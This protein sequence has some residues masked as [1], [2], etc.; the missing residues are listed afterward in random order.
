MLLGYPPSD[1][2]VRDLLTKGKSAKDAY[3][4]SLYFLLALLERTTRVITEDLKDAHDRSSRITKFR[5]FMTEGQGQIRQGQ[6]RV[7][8]GEKRRKYYQEVVNEVEDVSCI[9]GFNF[10]FLHFAENSNERDI[11]HF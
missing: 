3:I 5:E 2:S 1:D 11:V 6:I 4:C 9:Y 8:V 7:S 10:I